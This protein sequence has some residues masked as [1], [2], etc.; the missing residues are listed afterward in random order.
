MIL[1]GT[2][3]APD[4]GSGFDLSR[5]V[6]RVVLLGFA[7]I[8][9][10]LVARILL[11]LGVIPGDGALGDLVVR[12]SDASAAP[13]RGVTSALPPLLEGALTGFVGNSV[14]MTMVTA[15]AGWTVVEALVMRVVKKFDAI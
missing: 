13:V 4:S 2:R 6:R 9:G 8:Q 1:P 11:D 15:L 14:T 10:I 3:D 12:A 5:T 7:L